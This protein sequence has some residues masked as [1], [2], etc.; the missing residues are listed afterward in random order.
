[1]GQG[2]RTFTGPS[3]GPAG[4]EAKSGIWNL[5]LPTLHARVCAYVSACAWEG[6][7]TH[8]YACVSVHGHLCMGTCLLQSW[9]AAA[10]LSCHLLP[11][12][13]Q[14]SDRDSASEGDVAISGPG[15]LPV[16]A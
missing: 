7:C 5:S 2:P 6:V 16:V 15:F 3:G 10:S 13:G 14:S 4:N 8:R 12:L 9:I 1:M 11:S